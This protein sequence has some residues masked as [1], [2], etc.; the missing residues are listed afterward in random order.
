MSDGKTTP[1]KPK[2]NSK[3][4]SATVLKAGTPTSGVSTSGQ[5]EK[6]RKNDEPV[7]NF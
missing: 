4:S 6:Y 3:N 7:V 2:R 5:I 1:N